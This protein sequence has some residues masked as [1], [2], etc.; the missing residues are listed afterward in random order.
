MPERRSF[1]P[2]SEPAG[3]F[4]EI[5]SDLA[6][7][8]EAHQFIRAEGDFVKGYGHLQLEV[9]ALGGLHRLVMGL[10]PAIPEGA[11]S[12]PGPAAPLAPEDPAEDTFRGGVT[13]DIAEIA[14]PEDVFLGEFLSK[15]LGA[16]F[17]V[18]LLLLGIAQDGV[19]FA[20]LLKFLFGLF[21]VPLGFIGMVLHGQFPVSFFDVV[22]SGIPAHSQ[23]FIIIILRHDSSHHS[24]G[25]NLS[26]L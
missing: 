19:G 2:G 13:K 21:L 17:V 16:E 11:G 25:G 23:D 22:G 1:F 6:L 7:V 9:L 8:G 24:V 10:G 20:D 3:I 4:T 15:D 18:F 26:S 5:F 12:A 14:T